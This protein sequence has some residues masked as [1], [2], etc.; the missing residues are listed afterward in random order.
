MKSIY[1]FIACSILTF[2]ITSCG[3]DLYNTEQYK[4]EVYLVGGYNRVLTLDV[5]YNH[6]KVESHFTISS[7]G[8]LPLDQDVDISLKINNDLVDSYNKKYWGVM[9][10]DKYYMA[11]DQ[12]LYSIPSLEHN[13]I[14]HANGISVNVPLFIQTEELSPDISYV[15]PVQIENTT[16]YPVN[17]NGRKMLILLNLKNGYSGN[18]TM[19]GYTTEPGKTPRKMQKPKVVTAAGINDIRIFYAINNDSKEKADIQGKTI[20]VSILDESIVDNQKL[21]KVA[22]AAWNPE[23]LAVTDS[24]EGFYNPDTKTFHIKYTIN[25]IVYEENLTKEK[26]LPK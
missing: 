16:V 18:Y 15:I 25:N 21:K 26:E 23:T 14:L 2:F 6:E 24:G 13:T 4:K 9:N 19:D 8:S 3:E 10:L 5:M 12:S 1:K 22:V 7:S 17:E 20:K 11:L